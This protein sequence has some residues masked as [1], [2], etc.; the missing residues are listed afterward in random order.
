MG[1]PLLDGGDPP[2]LVET[3]GGSAPT[4]RPHSGGC[5]LD[6]GCNASS[7]SPRRFF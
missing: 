4:G 5:D 6:H 3:D 2:L 1:T 7:L